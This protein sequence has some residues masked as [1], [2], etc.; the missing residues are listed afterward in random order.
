M[1]MFLFVSDLWYFSRY[2]S[3]CMLLSGCWLAVSV[4]VAVVVVVVVAALILEGNCRY[5]GRVFCP[6]S[7]QL[8]EGDRR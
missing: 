6:A 1:W 2:L 4:A 7:T 8:S 3:C 5:K